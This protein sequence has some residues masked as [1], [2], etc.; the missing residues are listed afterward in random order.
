VGVPVLDP[1]GSITPPDERLSA[2]MRSIPPEQAKERGP[3]RE[4]VISILRR[5]AR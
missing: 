2:L 5:G 4:A 1:D 3:W